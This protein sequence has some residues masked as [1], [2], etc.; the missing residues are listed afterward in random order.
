MWV[1]NTGSSTENLRIDYFPTE[2]NGLRDPTNRATRLGSIW[3]QDATGVEVN[4]SA[5]LRISGED[6]LFVGD[7]GTTGYVSQ[8]TGAVDVST[9]IDSYFET[10]RE[11]ANLGEDIVK[12][13]KYIDISF[14]LS[15]ASALTYGHYID[16]DDVLETTRT[17]TDTPTGFVLGT[18]MLGTGVLGGTVGA[19]NRHRFGFYRRWRKMKHRISD[20]TSSQTRFKNIIN[21]GKILHG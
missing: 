16:D 1:A 3:L 10:K 6:Q 14:I 20:S 18:S 4:A 21:T 8:Q 19:P 15:G 17:F 11:T 9:D 7:N 2:I 13:I 5:E 12:S